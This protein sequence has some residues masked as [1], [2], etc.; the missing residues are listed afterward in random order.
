MPKILR[1]VGD[2]LD[3]V[4]GACPGGPRILSRLPAS[5]PVS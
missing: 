2:S 5:S 1:S 3:W 4:V